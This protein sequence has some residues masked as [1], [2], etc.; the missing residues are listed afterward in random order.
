MGEKT[1]TDKTRERKISRKRGYRKSGEERGRVKS[2]KMRK[3]RGFFFWK[4]WKRKGRERGQSEE[5]VTCGNRKER[6]QPS[7]YPMRVGSML[8]K[9]FFV[10]VLLDKGLL[11]W[12]KQQWHHLNWLSLCPAETK[13]SSHPGKVRLWGRGREGAVVCV[14]TRVLC[15]VSPSTCVQVC[16]NLTCSFTLHGLGAT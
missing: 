13:A 6:K 15:V 4:R 7:F 5:K 16:G 9:D 12:E 10:V 2:V 14:H 11:P 8:H 3:K 1:D